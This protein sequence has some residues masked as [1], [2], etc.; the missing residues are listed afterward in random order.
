MADEDRKELESILPKS[1]HK[2]ID[3]ILAHFANLG[4]PYVVEVANSR[5]A[6][7]SVTAYGLDLT[8]DA[9]GNAVTVES[10]YGFEVVE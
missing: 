9:H 2:K 4:F 8:L 5:V 6:V 7:E 3:E 10:Q 1:A